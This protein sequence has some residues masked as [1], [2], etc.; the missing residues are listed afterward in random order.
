M[1]F[2]DAGARGYVHARPV[3]VDGS[4]LDVEVDADAPVV[5]ASVF[6]IPFAVA[7]ARE[8]AAGR[9]D[10]VERTTVTARYRIGGIGTA[11]CADDVEMSWRDLA[12]LM[13]T[14]SDNA[15]TDMIYRRLAAERVQAVIDDVGLAGTRVIGCCEDLFATIGADLGESIDDVRAALAMATEE[16]VWKLSVLDPARTN[17]STPR[18]VTTLLNAIWTNTAAPAGACADVRSIMADQ[19][20]PHRL[21]S[22]FPSDV[23]LAAKTGTLPAVRNES[24]VVTYPDEQQYA[25]AV[26]TR[27]DTLA[28]HQPRIDAAIGT[29]ARMAVDRIRSNQ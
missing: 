4:D 9:L 17:A 16:Q 2:R 18:D 19:I 3:G 11:G 20:W 7:Y 6:K 1:V 12:R 25:V 5:L 21:T 23:R 22:G 29:A 13:M 28:E 27:A 15:A 14:M 24:G 26:F 8:V 10:P